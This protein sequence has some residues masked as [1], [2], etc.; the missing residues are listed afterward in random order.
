M[1]HRY[2]VGQVLDMRPSRLH[3]RRAGPCEVV[4]LLPHDS[5]PLLYRVRPLNDK[6]ER[7]VAEADLAEVDLAEGCEGS[8]RAAT[9]APRFTI[10]ISRRPV[11]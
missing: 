9:A 4:F 11:G 6:I 3:S 2:A 7:V 10:A 5:G 8:P 1:T